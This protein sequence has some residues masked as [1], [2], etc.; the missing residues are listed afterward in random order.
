MLNELDVHSV[1]IS[2]EEMK[3]VTEDFQGSFEGI[4]IEFDVIN[5]TIVVVSPIPGGPSER[6]VF[7]PETKLL[8]LTAKMQSGCR[9]RRFQKNF[10]DQKE[11]L[12][13]LILSVKE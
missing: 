3:R 6:L 9:V 8:K 1:F 5:D 7:V 10:V 12:L 4:G 11:L 13:K 2:A